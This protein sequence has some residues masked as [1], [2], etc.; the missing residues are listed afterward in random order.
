MHSRLEF[1]ISAIG[2][3]SMEKVQTAAIKATLNILNFW[4]DIW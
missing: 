4:H 1:L 2:K 3:K